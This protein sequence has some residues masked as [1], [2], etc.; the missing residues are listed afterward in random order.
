MNG[1][2]GATPSAASVVDSSSTCAPWNFTMYSARGMFDR[3]NA[4]ASA[5]RLSSATVG[6]RPDH[7]FLPT[8]TPQHRE[9]GSFLLYVGGGMRDPL[10]KKPLGPVQHLGRRQCNAGRVCHSVSKDNTDRRLPVQ[11]LSQPGLDL[12]IGHGGRSRFTSGA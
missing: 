10:G 6:P 3:F 2:L 9:L 5:W 11:Q 1:A 8:L 7:H 12:R 4:C